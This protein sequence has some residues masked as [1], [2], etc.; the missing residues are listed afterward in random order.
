MKGYYKMP[1]MPEKT[2]KVIEPAMKK[3]T[4]GSPTA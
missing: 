4:T 1:E 3:V 2:K